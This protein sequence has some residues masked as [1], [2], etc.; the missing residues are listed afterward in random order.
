[1][2]RAVL[3]KS[4]K[5]HSIKQQLLGHLRLISQTVQVRRT[6]HT[7]HCRESKNELIS[8]VLLKTPTYEPSFENMPRTMDDH[9]YQPLRSGRI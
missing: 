9:I 8:D 2:L 7:G 3:N 5:Q 4:W 1:M 6:K